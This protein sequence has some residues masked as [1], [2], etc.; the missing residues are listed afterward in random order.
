MLALANAHTARPKLGRELGRG[1]E[2]VV[3]ENLDQPGWVV[4]EFHAGSTSPLQ[5]ANE[6]ANLE[7]AR[8]FYPHNVVKA[9]SPAD[10]RQGWIVK[11]QVVGDI[12]APADLSAGKQI[13]QDFAN[14]GVQDVAGNL[15]FGHTADD[16]TPRWIL[17][18]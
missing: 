14:G 1:A 6:F 9:Q 15:I 12:P 10:P 5:A 18:E 13:E 11:E 16:P 17:L 8:A 4:K 2:G 7:K 3:Y